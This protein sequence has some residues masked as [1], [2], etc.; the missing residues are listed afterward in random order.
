MGCQALFI[1]VFDMRHRLS[2]RQLSGLLSVIALVVSVAWL[3]SLD[4]YLGVRYRFSLEATLPAAVA[5]VVFAP[6]RWLDDRV[7][8][9]GARPLFRLNW[10]SKDQLQA[11]TAA[12]LEMWKPP[13]EPQF[14]ALPLPLLPGQYKSSLTQQKLLSGPQRILLAGDSMMQGIAPFFMREVARSHPDWQVHDLSR[15]ST[16]LTMR[17]YFDWPAKLVDEMEAKNLT[18]VVIFLGPN[19]PWDL[20]AEGQRHLFPSPG[21]A[22]SYAMRVDEILAAAWQRQVRVIWVGLPA[23]QEGRIKEGAVLQNHIFHERASQW[24]TDYLATEPL[25]G[26]LSEPFQKFKV[27][28]DGQRLNLRADDGIHLTPLGQRWINQAL[29]AHIEQANKP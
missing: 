20:L 19:D 6:S 25:I 29:L 11:P 3:T 1:T 21:W 14:Q 23:M 28:D 12:T 4:K 2:S 16:G 26:L 5:D 22:T 8:S 13:A 18:L 10:P 17:R 27:K 7:R 15:Q 9:G 24:R